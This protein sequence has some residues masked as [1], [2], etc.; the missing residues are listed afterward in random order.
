ML[1]YR[2]AYVK[3]FTVVLALLISSFVST[4]Q[5]T[6]GI[7]S[8]CGGVD[9]VT[10]P[11]IIDND[12]DGMDDSLEKLLAIHFMPT[13]I[14]F[15]DES[16]PGPA[17]D[18]TG[19]SNLVVYAMYPFPQQ[20][21]RSNSYDSI[22]NHPVPVVPAHGLHAGL[23]WYSPLIMVNTAVLYGQDCGLLGHTA[24]VEGFSFSLKYIGPDSAAGWMY[25]TVMANWMGGT[26]Q[27]ISHAGTPCEQTETYPYKSALFP[28][29][30]DTV[31]ASPDKHGNYL[32]ISQC[33]AS[34]ICNP[35]CGNTQ[36]V[37]HVVPVNVGQPDYPL[38]S[39]LGTYYA[40]YAGNNPWGTAN[41]LDANGGNAGI[42][43]DKMIKPLSSDWIHG[44]TLTTAAI[45]P[46]YTNC[47]GT[48][49][50][51]STQQSC[52]GS[53][54][55]YG[56]Q[57]T[58]S[59]T[60]T[61]T[62]TDMYGC[63]STITLNLTVGTSTGYTYSDYLCAGNSYNFNGTAI[64][65]GGTYTYTIPNSTGCDS[66]ITL[67][68]SLHQ[69][70]IQNLNAA[71]CVG[72]NYQFGS[73]TLSTPGLYTDTLTAV[74][75][76]DSIIHLTLQ[77]DS[78]AV[79]TWAGGD[80]IISAGHPILLN[81]SPVGGVY[82][83]TGVTGNVFYPD[84]SAPGNYTVTYNYTD[85]NSCLSNASKVFVVNGITGISDIENISGIKIFPSPANAFL[86]IDAGT[87]NIE[88]IKIS[89]FAARL[90]LIF[91]PSRSFET[92]NCSLLPNGLYLIEINTGV[93]K[94]DYRFIIQ[95]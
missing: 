39:D 80:T 38:V 20:Y 25:D 60:Y 11:N 19:D 33:G 9:S 71:F 67:Q 34:F 40:A 6:V 95:R 3:H 65:T 55:F 45:C 76:C 28:N 62:L 78:G 63:D 88:E 57:L 74:N 10:I 90:I 70:V 58:Q 48:P 47:Y 26:I 89:D 44:T 15:S 30:K 2:V 73:N 64:T 69:P 13:V 53:Y 68:L 75:G 41:F 29:G 16:C 32:T 24:D 83:G 35:G 49:G 21:T 86:N 84:S 81:A 87:Q 17:L 94:T 27:T 43:S 54:T 8:P 82:S 23:I 50:S 1:R 79:I 42:I 56:Q 72:S 93:Q 91:K 85:G 36:S 22:L 92:I 5:Q 46:L 4:A 18:G 61:H 7:I 52:T 12:H 31:Y 14:Q 37:K 77:V 66:V 59:G 51:A